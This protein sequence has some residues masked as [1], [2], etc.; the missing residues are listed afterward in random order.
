MQNGR[1]E[2]EH[3]AQF[4]ESG[5]VVL[6]R[7]LGPSPLTE[8]CDRPLSEAFRTADSRHVLAQWSE[9]SA[10]GTYR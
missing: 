2:A 9:R 7:A 1:V 10:F 3:R 5:F 4:A 6:R 8:E